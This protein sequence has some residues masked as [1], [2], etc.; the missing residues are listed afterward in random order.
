MNSRRP[1]ERTILRV[2]YETLDNMIEQNVGQLTRGTV[3]QST[4]TFSSTTSPLLHIAGIDT[5]VN[6]AKSWMEQLLPS[7]HNPRGVVRGHAPQT[8][9]VQEIVIKQ[10]VRN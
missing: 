6:F 7:V 3:T 10:A 2:E 5:V 9:P 4:A 1:K 8:V